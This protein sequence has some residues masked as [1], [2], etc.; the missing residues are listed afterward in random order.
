MD[1]TNAKQIVECEPDCKC[2]DRTEKI[3]QN[4]YRLSIENESFRVNSGC[5]VICRG[6]CSFLLVLTHADSVTVGMETC[7]FGEGVSVPTVFYS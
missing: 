4:K 2:L 7:D 5:L 6:S 1:G 3:R